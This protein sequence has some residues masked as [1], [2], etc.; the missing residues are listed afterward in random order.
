MIVAR[1]AEQKPECPLSTRAR[2][3]H[4]PVQGQAG[5]FI[6]TSGGR[7]FVPYWVFRSFS[8]LPEPQKLGEET[9]EPPGVDDDESA[10]SRSRPQSLSKYR[11]LKPGTPKVQKLYE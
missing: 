11:T 9:P 3:S 6:C 8:T 1:P 7:N 4:N 2:G 5:F 10:T